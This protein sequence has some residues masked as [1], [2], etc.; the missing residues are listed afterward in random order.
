MF[1]KAQTIHKVVDV[2]VW[3]YLPVAMTMVLFSG[4]W[5]HDVDLNKHF[6]GLAFS[7]FYIAETGGC[8][9]ANRKFRENLIY[10][11]FLFLFGEMHLCTL[12]IGKSQM[13]DFGNVK[14]TTAKQALT[15]SFWKGSKNVWFSIN[16]L[17]KKIKFSGPPRGPPR[18][19]FQCCVRIN[20]E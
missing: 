16:S 19:E 6:Q 7:V 9:G 10:F 5:C 3:Q 2:I 13:F 14:T 18:I 8:K 4:N 1:T 11:S 15:I 12:A 20:Y 17:L